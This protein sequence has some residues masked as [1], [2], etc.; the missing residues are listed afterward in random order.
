MKRIKDN[1]LMRFL[2][3]KI[4]CLVLITSLPVGCTK[5][6]DAAD[7]AIADKKAKE[8]EEELLKF[9]T[10][11]MA[12]P[13][14]YD[15]I[16]SKYKVCQT[17]DDCIY[18]EQDGGCGN[19][20]GYRQVVHK[21]YKNKFHK[22]Y[23][24]SEYGR[25]AYTSHY[26]SCLFQNNSQVHCNDQKC[27]SVKYPWEESWD[28]IFNNRNIVMAKKRLERYRSKAHLANDIKTWL[29][30]LQ[31]EDAEFLDLL[32]SHGLDPSFILSNN[33]S[34]KWR[35]YQCCKPLFEVLEKYGAKFKAD[36]NMLYLIE[37]KNLEQIKIQLRDP[38]I[39]ALLKTNDYTGS[40]FITKPRVSPFEHNKILAHALLYGNADILTALVKTGVNLRAPIHIQESY[41]QIDWGAIDGS[42]ENIKTLIKLGAKFDKES[43]KKFYQNNNQYLQEA[44]RKQLLELLDCKSKDC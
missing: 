7:E 2:L 35:Y 19:S 10:E 38:K 33:T 28:L 21:K 40:N 12:V 26:A 23:K 22:P 27:Q 15:N 16:P 13:D 29:N 1:L 32:L 8:R 30:H 18:L 44:H 37:N 42:V 3:Q 4:A 14:P 5:K 39:R 41:A 6:M 34:L 36:E 25:A 31:F 9:T 11:R 24:N 17:D 20:S 43:L